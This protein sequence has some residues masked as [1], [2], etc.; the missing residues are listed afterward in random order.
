MQKEKRK[1]A[2]KYIILSLLLLTLAY[3]YFFTS[4]R[5]YITIESIQSFVNQ[6]GMAAP[7]IFMIIYIIALLLLLPASLFSIAGGVLFGVIWGTIYV[8]IAAT[9]AATIAFLF[10]R[11]LKGKKRK[12]F[13]NK[14]IKTIVEK[15]ENHCEI[16]GFKTFFI[17]R[18]LYLPYMP[19]SY[20]AGLVHSAKL[21]DFVSATF[22]T[23]IVGSFTFVYFGS[24]IQN[25]LTAL[26][27][28]TVL[29][30][31]TLL[32]PKIVKKIRKEEE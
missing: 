19:L 11:K 15:C 21:K 27:I 29:I 23:N 4:L 17:L 32:I 7:F 10:A 31:L 24:Q 28:P 25:G 13:S 12:E 14:F 1:K 8:V 26:I 2:I 6:F 3:I 5:S 18:L 30:I 16:N 22:L 20:A 9:V